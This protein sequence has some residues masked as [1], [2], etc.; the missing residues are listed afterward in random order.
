[1]QVH[2]AA[3]DGARAGEPIGGGRED[4]VLHP[5]AAV[6]SRGPGE[7]DTSSAPR[8]VDPGNALTGTYWSTSGTGVATGVVS[9]A[10][11]EQQD[12]RGHARNPATAT[13]PSGRVPVAGQSATDRRAAA[14]LR[15]KTGTSSGRR[16]AEQ[17]DGRERRRQVRGRTCR[18]R[19]FRGSTTPLRTMNA[20]EPAADERPRSRR[21]PPET[22]SR[23]PRPPTSSA[24]GSTCTRGCVDVARAGVTQLPRR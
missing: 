10:E 15:P 11:H 13:T 14:R 22:R 18:R 3:G 2:R 17:E 21:A 19:R 6:R 23:P 9:W 20:R 16:R 5:G 7:R 8:A 1:M 4:R 24:A 12:E